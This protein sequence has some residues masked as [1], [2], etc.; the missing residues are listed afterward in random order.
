MSAFILRSYNTSIRLAFATSFHDTIC[1]NALVL[2]HIY[3]VAY[4]NGLLECPMMASSFIVVQ[5][6]HFCCIQKPAS[7]C[8][9]IRHIHGCLAMALLSLC[10]CA[11]VL[12][13]SQNITMAAPIIIKIRNI[14]IPPRTTSKNT[15]NAIM[16]IP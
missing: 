12:R 16:P 9:Q 7:L 15:L 4:C 8:L 3:L 10:F 5:Q 6:A 11:L 13:Y 1:F 14:L 2:L